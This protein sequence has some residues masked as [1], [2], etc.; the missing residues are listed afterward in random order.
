MDIRAAVSTLRGR[1]RP[2]RPAGRRARKNP[3]V[4]A[5]GRRQLAP[6]ENDPAGIAR[7]PPRMRISQRKQSK[8]V[9][10]LMIMPSERF[11][12]TSNLLKLGNS[13]KKPLRILRI[14]LSSGFSGSPRRHHAAAEDIHLPDQ[15]GENEVRHITDHE[16]DEAQQHGDRE[17]QERG[18]PD[19][20]D[21]DESETHEN[22]RP[23][24][25][26]V[27]AE[28]RSRVEHLDPVLERERRPDGGRLIPVLGRILVLVGDLQRSV[29]LH[30]VGGDAET[31]AAF[32]RRTR[33][34]ASCTAARP[35]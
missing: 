3:H 18:G 29:G 28:R 2:F 33:P 14:A 25:D 20:D 21:G 34:P 26:D 24:A 13:M 30:F 16:D 27:L 22:D 1:R 19:S 9:H 23:R 15:T 10:R 17:G 35:R 8:A 12:T 31:C 11:G 7:T 6:F 5:A 4:A 32:R